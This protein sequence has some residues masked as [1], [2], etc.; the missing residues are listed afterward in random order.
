MS[1]FH[2]AFWAPALVLVRGISGVLKGHFECHG[3]AIETFGQRIRTVTHVCLARDIG[4]VAM[5]GLKI[6]ID[7]CKRVLVV[8]EFCQAG[9]IPARDTLCTG[10]KVIRQG[11]V[12]M[13]IEHKMHTRG[14]H[15]FE[16]KKYF[17]GLAHGRS[18]PFA[19]KINTDCISA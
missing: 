3:L 19:V 16:Y 8:L 14:Y 15:F 9:I 17:R 4:R 12:T 6:R 13:Y 11:L 7:S 10:D 5:F 18:I 2:A 1:Q